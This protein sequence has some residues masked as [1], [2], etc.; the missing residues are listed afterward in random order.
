MGPQTWAARSITS[1]EEDQDE[2]TDRAAREV[3]HRPL[4]VGSGAAPVRRAGV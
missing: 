1:T 2:E 3:G 4:W